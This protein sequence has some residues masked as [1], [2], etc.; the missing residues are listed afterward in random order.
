MGIPP[1]AE[2]RA[3]VPFLL[4]KEAAGFKYNKVQTAQIHQMSPL[5]KI[6][7]TNRG[8][9]IQNSLRNGEAQIRMR[10]AHATHPCA[11]IPAVLAENYKMVGR[12]P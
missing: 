4:R 2:Y 7:N 9:S 1:S 8:L 5:H 11:I 12:A 10:L 3:L 6:R